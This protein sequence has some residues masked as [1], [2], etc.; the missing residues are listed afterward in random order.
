MSTILALDTCDRT[1]GVA[2]AIGGAVACS[3][4]ENSPQRHSERLLALVDE[5]LVGVGVEKG[6]LDGIAVTRGPGSFTGVRV[7][8]AT[9]KGLAFALGIPV[10]GVSSL[11]ALWGSAAPFPGVVVPLLDARKGQVYATARHGWEGGGTLMEEGAWY[12]QQ[13]LEALADT[14]QP[15]LFLG[16]GLGA[17][18][19]TFARGLGERFWAAP[20]TR[21]A[22]HPGAVAVAG[23]AA[24]RRGEAMSPGELTPTYRRL[25]EAEQARGKT[26]SSAL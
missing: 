4:V 24:L 21:W 23:A 26:A 11:T 18:R 20:E 8:I 13:V 6:D 19:D 10:L 7:G 2:V 15:C 5:A 17:Y 12:P 22:I 9:A 14:E 25:S 1:V 3:R 16:S